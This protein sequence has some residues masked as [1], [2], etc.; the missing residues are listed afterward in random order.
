MFILKSQGSLCQ[1]R[2]ITQLRFAVVY[3][4]LLIISESFLQSHLVRL[5]GDGSP[6]TSCATSGPC[7][8]NKCFDPKNYLVHGRYSIM[9]VLHT[10]NTS[11]P[12]LYGIWVQLQARLNSNTE[13]GTTSF[14]SAPGPLQALQK[15]AVWTNA[16]DSFHVLMSTSRIH[17]C[18]AHS[19]SCQT[20]L[21]ILLAV[22]HCSG[23]SQPCRHPEGQL[24]LAT[25]LV[26]VQHIK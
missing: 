12:P 5:D 10:L 23:P 2:R 20:K 7:Q 6:C 14:L 22:A 24:S 3:W 1:Q 11:S 8:G 19:V 17:I 26:E 18:K 16:D 4:Q 13:H 15:T 25:R 9:V 21:F